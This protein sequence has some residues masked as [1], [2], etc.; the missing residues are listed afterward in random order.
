MRLG[1]TTV[2]VL[3]SMMSIGSSGV[4]A[5]GGQVFQQQQFDVIRDWLESNKEIKK[6]DITELFRILGNANAIDHGQYGKNADGSVK[7][8]TTFSYTT[9]SVPLATEIDRIDIEVLDDSSDVLRMTFHLAPSACA[10]SRAFAARYGLTLY[11]GPEPNPGAVVHEYSKFFEDGNLD[12]YDP[13]VDGHALGC[14]SEV[15]VFV[16]MKKP[17]RKH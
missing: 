4:R 1:A 2:C 7:T 12:I 3:A 6:S 14:V 10:N 15:H 17:S 9:P 16:N 8:S 11:T 13:I 5:R